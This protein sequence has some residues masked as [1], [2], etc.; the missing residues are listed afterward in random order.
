M[1]ATTQAKRLRRV[2]RRASPEIVAAVH[3]GKLSIRLADQLLYLPRKEQKAELRSRL[4]AIEDREWQSAI[5]ARTIREYLDQ[6][7]GKRVDLIELGS[8]IRAA[9]SSVHPG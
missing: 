1:S 9:L 5:T 3:A 8:V 4:K 2:E 6:L 7:G